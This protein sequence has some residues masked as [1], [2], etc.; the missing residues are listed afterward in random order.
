MFL[1]LVGSILEF[2]FDGLEASLV[3]RLTDVDLLPTTFCFMSAKT[4]QLMPIQE[5]I[6]VEGMHTAF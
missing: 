3:F 6:I 2:A 5:H 1:I 4:I